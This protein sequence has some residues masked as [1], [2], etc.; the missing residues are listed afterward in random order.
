MLF[1]EL[2]GLRGISRDLTIDSKGK[3]LGEPNE[4]CKF[5]LISNW[6]TDDTA[7]QNLTIPPP[8]EEGNN[9]GEAYQGSEVYYGYDKTFAHQLFAGKDTYFL[10]C[11]N[12][13]QISVKARLGATRKIFFTYFF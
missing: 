7:A 4:E 6:T 5:V 8:V 13:G 11:Q 1:P 12:L 9:L 2:L 3:P 10:P